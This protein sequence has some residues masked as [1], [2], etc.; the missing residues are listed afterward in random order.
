MTPLRPSQRLTEALGSNTRRLNSPHFLL[1]NILNDFSRVV[2][3][4]REYRFDHRASH[5][6]HRH[7]ELLMQA[8][9]RPTSS[10]PS[11]YTKS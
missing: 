6:S 9:A 3:T 5:L 1:Y 2:E 7:G 4:L 10:V 8:S 11:A